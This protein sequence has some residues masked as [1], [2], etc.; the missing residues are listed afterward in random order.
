MSE[1]ILI[2]KHKNQYKANLHC[3]S[4]LSDGRLSPCELKKL[5]KEN[6]YNILSI[7]DHC[8]PNNHSYLSDEEFLMLT[9]YE[10]YIRPTEGFVF[11]KFSSEIHLNLFAKEPDNETLICYNKASVKYIPEERLKALKRS[12]S[13]RTREYS[14]DYVNEFINTANANGYLVA[15]NHS[16]W[17]MEDE[18]R[19][20]SY[21]NIFSF[22]MYNTSSY[23]GNN[24]ENGELLYDKM[25]RCGMHIGCHAGDDNHNKHPFESPY[26]DSCGYHTVILSDDLEYSSVISALENKDY[27]AS[28]A[29][30]I[31]ELKVKDNSLVHIETSPVSKVFMFYG[32]LKSTVSVRLPHGEI[33]TSFDLPLPKDAKFIRIS[34]YDEEGCVANTRGFLPYEWETQ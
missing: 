1:T 20:L 19:I 17:S 11:D 22:E 30:R 10:A 2:S 27:Y 26:N 32:S 31:Y 29:P 18:E 23:I 21:K 12:G 7:T 5:Y 6:G 8:S 33:S 16:C 13:E 9:G 24:L 14:K 4:T 34:V 25:L 3:H 15:Y 28:N